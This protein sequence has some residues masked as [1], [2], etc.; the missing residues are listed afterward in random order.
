[1]LDNP[2][3]SDFKITC[4]NRTF[5]CHRFVI[6][7]QSIPLAAVIDAGLKEID[8]RTVDL[9]NDDATS[10]ESLL[11]YLYTGGYQHNNTTE[12]KTGNNVS[13][14]AHTKVYLIAKK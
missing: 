1:M 7:T 10:V 8:T 6:C 11:A 14:L 5:N 4:H 9:P 2:K 13:L 3:Y 12:V